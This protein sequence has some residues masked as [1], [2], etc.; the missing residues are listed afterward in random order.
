MNLSIC[1]CLR[2]EEGLG[3]G[4]CVFS[5]GEDQCSLERPYCACVYSVSFSWAMRRFR[6]AR[7]RVRH[8]AVVRREGIVRGLREEETVTVRI[9]VVRIQG[10]R[11][12][13]RCAR[14]LGGAGTIVRN[15]A[16]PILAGETTAL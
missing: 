16:V 3:S 5:L 10:G 6:R 12:Y 8:L 13:S 15:R 11:R 14:I 9:R 4:N 7:R 2:V 1:L